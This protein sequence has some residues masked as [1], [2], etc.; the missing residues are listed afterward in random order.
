[1]WPRGSAPALA[2]FA[3]LACGSSSPKGEPT[4]PTTSSAAPAPSTG[5]PTAPPG[6]GEPTPPAGGP[7]PGGPAPISLVGRWTSPKCGARGYVRNLE[8]LDGG[9]FNA[10]DRVSPCPP[11]VS[12]VWSG[13]VNRKGIWS[14]ESNKVTLATD[15]DRDPPKQGAAWAGS[16]ELRGGELVEVQGSE[17]C[18]Y[19]KQ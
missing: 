13:I 8:L 15:K 1:M 17:R 10:E 3:L 5:G 11:K 16:L 6:S 12:C 14:L 7:P 4:A 9:R 19:T 2:S 18:S